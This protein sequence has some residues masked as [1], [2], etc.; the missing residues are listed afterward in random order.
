[1]TRDNYLNSLRKINQKRDKAI[2]E[3]N[4]HY[5]EVNSPHKRGDIIKDDFKT[6]RI[7]E[8]TYMKGELLDFPTCVYHGPKLDS[9]NEIIPGEWKRIFECNVIK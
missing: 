9:G 3:L 4:T 6:I 2:R 5:V 8:I 7:E 1:M